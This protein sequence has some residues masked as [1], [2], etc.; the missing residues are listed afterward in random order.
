MPPFVDRWFRHWEVDRKD[1]E[2]YRVLFSIYLLLGSPVTHWG[3]SLGP[4]QFSP[5]ESLA[6]LFPSL[7]ADGLL[8][9]IESIVVLA[10][11]V[12]CSGLSTRWSSWVI[13]A[14]STLLLSIDFAWTGRWIDFLLPA[15]AMVMATCAWEG[16]RYEQ[17]GELR[18]ARFPGWSIGM[19][20]LMGGIWMT[21]RGYAQ[22]SQGWL[23]SGQR[24]LATEVFLN[25][26]GTMRWNPSGQ[27]ANS[28]VP[29]VW[30]MG[31]LVDW[32]SV[33][34]YGLALLFVF[35]RRICLI[36][37]ALAVWIHAASYSLGLN[38]QGPLLLAYGA[39]V[40]WSRVWGMVLLPQIARHMLT[41]FIATLTIFFLIALIP[42]WDRE[43]IAIFFAAVTCL[44]LPLTTIFPHLAISTD[45]LDIEKEEWAYRV[46]GLRILAKWIFGPPKSPD[47]R[48][49]LSN[50]RDENG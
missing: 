27:S 4:I 23:D 17:A 2:I 31:E 30:Q 22:W 14:G 28:W 47:L 45:L 16:P 21:M 1:L 36:W 25:Q 12:L 8:V 7:P 3:N 35:H 40:P 10:A 41:A 24:G 6:A 29:L 19:C 5:R 26:L 42:G 38:G 50:G 20:V 34:F 9:V 32:V 33:L 43:G 13:A 39:A 18:E 44:Y 11:L 46:P 37:L 15:I 48:R 49:D